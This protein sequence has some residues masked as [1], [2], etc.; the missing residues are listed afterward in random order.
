MELEQLSETINNRLKKHSLAHAKFE[1][2]FFDDK[3]IVLHPDPKDYFIGSK[4]T[5]TKS[6]GWWYL[7]YQETVDADV[8]IKF[9]IKSTDNADDI[10]EITRF[11]NNHT[12]HETP[13]EVAEET[14]TH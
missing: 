10:H 6:L 2:G 14:T 1:E 7:D 8:S 13:Q 3:V 4:I 11:V 5:I 12:M 9:Q